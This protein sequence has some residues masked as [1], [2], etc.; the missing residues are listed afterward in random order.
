MHKKQHTHRHQNRLCEVAAVHLRHQMIISYACPELVADERVADP[1]GVF[2]GRKTRIPTA[3]NDQQIWHLTSDM[4]K[5][6]FGGESFG[7]HVLLAPQHWTSD[8]VPGVRP[9]VSYTG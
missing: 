9:D 7:Y 8:M 3:R 1:V 6:S 5:R 2:V 4:L